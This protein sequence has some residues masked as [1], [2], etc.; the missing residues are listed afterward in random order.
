MSGNYGGSIEHAIEIVHAAKN[1]GADCLKLQTYTAETLT[2]KCDA[3]YFRF[4]VACGLTGIFMTSIQ[5]WNS[6]NIRKL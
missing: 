1:S 6:V 3:P 2:L 4:V 5:R